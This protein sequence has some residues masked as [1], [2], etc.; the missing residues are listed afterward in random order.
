MAKLNISSVFSVTRSFR[1]HI[2]WFAAQCL[3]MV[4]SY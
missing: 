3:L 2:C 4:L 1:N